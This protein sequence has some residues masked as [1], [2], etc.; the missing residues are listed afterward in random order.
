MNELHV[1]GIGW[2]GWHG[3]GKGVSVTTYD[4][5]PAGGEGLAKECV[6]GALVYD[7]SQ[8]DDDAFAK[9]VVNGPMVNPSMDP[10]EAEGYGSFDYVGIN[11]YRR[12]LSEVPGMRL[13][14]VQSGKI[15][16]D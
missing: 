9:L 6:D 4:A 16:W 3:K 13:G 12:L 7:A 10:D 11:V 15:V 8:A 5:T 1:I 14:T 2:R